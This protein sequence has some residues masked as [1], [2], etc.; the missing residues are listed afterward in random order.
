MYCGTNKTALQSQRQIAE[1]MMALLGRKP[2]SQ[3]TDSELL[4]AVGAIAFSLGAA[5]LLSRMIRL[6]LPGRNGSG[7]AQT[8]PAA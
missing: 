7:A 6:I 5:W 4:R 8:D 3:I 1:A 2:F